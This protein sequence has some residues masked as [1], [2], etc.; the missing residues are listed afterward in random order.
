[1]LISELRIGD[2]IRY[3]N[4]IMK[5]TNLE[6]TNGKTLKVSF[7]YGDVNESKAEKFKALNGRDHFLFL[8]KKREVERC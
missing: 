5:I 8:K 4:R 1:M 2:T 6:E 7:I 3:N